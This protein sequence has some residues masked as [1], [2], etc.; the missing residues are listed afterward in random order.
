M[1]H[2]SPTTCTSPTRMNAPAGHVVFADTQ[3]VVAP[4]V[5]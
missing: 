3:H 2:I 5:S 1:K 4:I